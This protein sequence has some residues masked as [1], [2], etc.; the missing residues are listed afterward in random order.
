MDSLPLRHIV[1][2]VQMHRFKT[3]LFAMAL[4]LPA[5]PATAD[6]I[7]RPGGA[8]VDTS[9]AAITKAVEASGGRVFT[10]VDF[11]AGSARIGQPLRPTKVVIFG[12][13]QIGA[14]ALQAGQTLA[15]FLPL[16][17]LAYEDAEG[18]IW[19]TWDDPASVAETHSVPAGDPG[20]QRMR[21]ALE[22]M[23]GIAAGA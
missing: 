21:A 4:A 8:S 17:I 12:G 14:S 18:S 19:L 10:V 3:I 22:K 1:T 6:L 9:V 23:A 5:L 20:V 15:L 2:E 13:P 11:A 7:K 16:R